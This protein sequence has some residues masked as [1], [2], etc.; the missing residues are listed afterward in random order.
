MLAAGSDGKAAERPIAR[1]TKSR[2]NV[3]SV[4]I[5][6]AIGYNYRTPLVFIVKQKSED[7]GKKLGVN[8]QRYVR[9]CLL[10][11]F[12]QPNP[13]PAG[14]VFMQDGARCHVA[15]QSLAY[16]E[17]KGQR[18]M[19]NWP[20]YSPDLNPIELLW[21]ELD[22]RIA[23]RVPTSVEELKR[24]AQEE[25]MAIPTTLINDFV[26]HFQRRLRAVPDTL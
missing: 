9:C 5:W 26:I 11:L 8:A 1:V 25:W 18:L 2:F 15:K 21:A 7:E 24:I 6:A 12:S 16:L 13:I 20:P 23:E 22:R 19:V 4:M 10:K 3:P 14:R 17:R